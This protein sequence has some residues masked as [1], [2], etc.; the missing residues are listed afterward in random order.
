MNQWV[1]LNS[2]DR[3]V[4]LDEYILYP[5]IQNPTSRPNKNLP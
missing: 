5:Y 4:I 1:L 3:Q 2:D